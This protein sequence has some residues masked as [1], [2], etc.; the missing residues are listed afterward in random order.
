MKIILDT[1][2]YISA[3]CFGGN[4]I[5]V[6]EIIQSFNFEIFLSNEI[7][8]EIRAKFLDGRVEKILKG[9]FIEKDAIK[10]LDLIKLSTL[11]HNPKTKTTLCRDPKDNIILELAGEIGANYII[12]GDKDL[13]VLNPFVAGNQKTQIVTVSQF[14]EILGE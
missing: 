5:K 8:E 14:L 3:F 13:L 12:T 4:C 9:K 1:N 10:F 7:Y 2:I 11:N 6:L